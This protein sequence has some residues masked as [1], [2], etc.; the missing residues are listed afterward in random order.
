MPAPMK[1]RY[2]V[3]MLSV[4]A[5]CAARGADFQDSPQASV[6][7]FQTG[8]KLVLVPV[9]VRDREGRTV[10]DLGR[11]SFEVFDK[12][13]P[14]RIA[15]FSVERSEA[16]APTKQR[17]RQPRTPAHFIAYFFDDVSAA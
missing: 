8:A 16:A 2:A 10:A 5:A 7:T 11:D 15:A 1:G 4:L 17:Q 12:S 14:Q 3:A 13:K 9:V 6:P